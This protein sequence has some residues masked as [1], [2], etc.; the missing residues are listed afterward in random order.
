MPILNDTGIHII[1]NKVKSDGNVKMIFSTNTADDV[2]INDDG[3]VL[4]EFIT[5]VESDG[6]YMPIKG[7]EISADTIPT[8]ALNAIL[9]VSQ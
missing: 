9:N 2:I 4:T 5:G 1:P 3:D 6:K 8:E 7:T